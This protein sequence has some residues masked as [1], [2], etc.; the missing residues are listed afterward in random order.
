ML[1][2]VQVLARAA[3]LFLGSIGASLWLQEQESGTPSPAESLAQARELFTSTCNACHVPPDPA[4]AV[5]RAWLE[6]VRD[7]A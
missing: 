5:D 1:G 7:T 2:A 3:A 4:F 6:Q